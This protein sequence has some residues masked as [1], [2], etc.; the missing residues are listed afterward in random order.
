MTTLTRHCA[1]PAEVWGPGYERAAG[2]LRLYVAQL[3]RKLGPDPAR[4]R[5]LITVPGMG[6][7][8]ES[9]ARLA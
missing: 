5:W 2:N 1:Q 8:F 4:P 6:Y 7:R 3:R 9:A